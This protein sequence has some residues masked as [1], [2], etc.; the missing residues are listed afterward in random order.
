MKWIAVRALFLAALSSALPASAAR[1]NVDDVVATLASATEFPEVAASPDGKRAAWIEERAEGDRRET[2]LFVRSVPPAGP[3]VSIAVPS[4]GR[5][6]RLHAIAFS[7]DSATLAFVASDDETGRSILFL[8]PAAGGK[9]KRLATF[10]GALDAPSFSPDGRSIAFLAVEKPSKGAGPLGPAA[11]ATGVIGEAE[12]ADVQRIALFDVATGARTVASPVDLYVYEF[13]WF[14]SGAAFAVTAAPPPGDDHWWSARLMTIDR[15]TATPHAVHTPAEQIA[16][17]TVSPDGKSIAFIGGLMSD[18]GVT[19]GDVFVVD[20]AGGTP[21]NLTPGRRASATSARWLAAG[22]ILLTEIAGGVPAVSVVDP[23]TSAV[24]TLRIG[25]ER[26]SSGLGLGI[27][28]SKD[29]A[30]IAAVRSSFDETEEIV[31]GTPAD[32]KP[33]TSANAGLKPSWGRGKSVFVDRE[34]AGVE[35]WYVRGFEG[36]E[37]KGARHPLVV[38]VHGGPASAAVPRWP[39]VLAAS[40]LSQGYDVL[41]PNPRGSFGQ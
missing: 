36:D 22:K 1:P 19:G 30:M 34:G 31:A 9:A 13:D 2:R 24:E 33:L 10:D 41:F 37:A 40:L 18:Q 3:A 38:L 6:P 32:L 14:P 12:S 5:R 39:S 23:K 25:R 35:G 20:A 7:P 16:S 27:S 11:R 21:R 17:P 26:L 4:A 29:V 28:S 8:A 15:A